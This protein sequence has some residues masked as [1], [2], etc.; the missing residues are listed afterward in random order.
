MGYELRLPHSTP[1]R[2]FLRADLPDTEE[3]IRRYHIHLMLFTS[4]EWKDMLAFR[5]YL[6]VHP[7]EMQHYAD[8]KK[9]AAAEVC[10]NGIKYRELKG[11]VFRKVLEMVEMKTVNAIRYTSR[12]LVLT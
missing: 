12:A 3:S 1:D 8:V 9:Q 5:D 4:K 11:P 10:E 7:I 2:L 6:R